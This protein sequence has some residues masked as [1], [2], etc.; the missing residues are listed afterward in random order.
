MVWQVL[1][2]LVFLQHRQIIDRVSTFENCR[3]SCACVLI[4]SSWV[5]RRSPFEEVLCCVEEQE[6]LLRDMRSY[7]AALTDPRSPNA[8]HRLL[9]ELTP[10]S[11]PG[12]RRST[13][14]LTGKSSRLIA[15]PYA[16][17]SI[18]ASRSAIRIM[19]SP[20]STNLFSLP[21]WAE[22]AHKSRKLY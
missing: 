15:K 5:G 21:S 16:A 17:R 9:K 22:R 10:C 7:F 1:P 14:P 11:S 20:L 4:I 2:R 12:S 19:K 6:T 13:R 18:R 8:R 3:A